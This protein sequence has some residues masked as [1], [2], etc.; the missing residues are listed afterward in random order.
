[1]AQDIDGLMALYAA[2]AVFV[3]PVGAVCKGE[4][5]ICA[6]HEEA[7]RAHWPTPEPR[8]TLVAAASASVE[9]EAFLP[10]GS[11]RHTANFFY[12]DERNRIERLVV[13][14]QD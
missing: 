3:L 10:D 11:I 12:F 1:M 13:Y 2:N 6:L 7:F 9:C 5:A 14:R 4:R 8:S